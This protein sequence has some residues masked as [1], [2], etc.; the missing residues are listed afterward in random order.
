[1]Q[2]CGLASNP[3]PN[4]SK[5]DAL[6]TCEHEGG[7]AQPKSVALHLALTNA[8]GVRVLSVA[9]VAVRGQEER[10]ECL[11]E[12]RVCTYAGEGWS[13]CADWSGWFGVV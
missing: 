9:R 11:F 2:E 1:M 8:L 12:S 13:A 3:N 10:R 7:D 6:R 5:Y 4:P